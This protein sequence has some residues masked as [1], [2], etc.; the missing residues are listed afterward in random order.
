MVMALRLGPLNRN[1]K[2]RGFDPH[3]SHYRFLLGWV[4]YGTW[5]G[6]T[7][8]LYILLFLEGMKRGVLAFGI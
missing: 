2:E 5:H 6:E 7:E 4:A 8:T 1:S 3:P